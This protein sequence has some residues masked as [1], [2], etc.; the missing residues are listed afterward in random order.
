M[1]I[2]LAR[3]QPRR[4]EVL[5][6]RAVGEV[7]RFER[8][9]LPVRLRTSVLAEALAVEEVSAVELKSRLV[10]QY[11]HHAARRRLVKRSYQLNP[12][13]F[14]AQHPVVVVAVAVLQSQG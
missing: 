7:L 8:Y 14:A 13:A 2:G 11:L 6:V 9:R 1:R 4:R 10:G 5:V 12:I 3:I